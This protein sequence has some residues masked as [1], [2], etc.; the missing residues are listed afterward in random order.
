MFHVKLVIHRL[1]TGLYT[2][3][4][5]KKNIQRYNTRS[6]RTTRRREGGS[7]EYY[8]IYTKKTKKRSQKRGKIQKKFNVEVLRRK[9][10]KLKNKL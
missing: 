9:I 3:K 7:D 1:S 5:C 6:D 4:T 2:Y 8:Y 10:D